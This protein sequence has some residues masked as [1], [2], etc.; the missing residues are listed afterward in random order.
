MK[1]SDIKE[2]TRSQL[3]IW[4]LAGLVVTGLVAAGT[5]YADAQIALALERAFARLDLVTG[6]PNAARV[7]LSVIAGAMVSLLVFTFTM[8]MVVIQLASSQ[9]SP[10]LMRS[11]LRDRPTKISL[12]LFICTFAYALI[13]LRSVIDQPK[14]TVV[15]ELSIGVTY[16]LVLACLFAFIM[17]VDHVAH[18]MR[19]GTVIER[20]IEETLSVINRTKRSVGTPTSHPAPEQLGGG[21]DIRCPT[22][23]S[24]SHLDEKRLLALASKHDATIQILHRVGDHV[25][26]GCP[27]VRIYDA[28]VDDSDIL[29]LISLARTRTMQQDVAFGF[30]QILDIANRALS[31]GINDSTT[32]VQCIDG[33]H[34]LLRRLLDEPDLPAAVAGEQ[35]RGLLLV[36][37]TTWRDYVTLASTEVRI[38]GAGSPQVARRLEAMLRDLYSAAPLDRRAPIEQELRLL[39]ASV[40]EVVALAAD[41]TLFEQPDE[42]GLGGAPYQH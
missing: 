24:V 7:I 19:V 11:V 14:L 32:A 6:D 13:V 42:Q 31:P 4:P 18:T 29:E 35:D 30:R 25:P 38:Y 23:G 2:Y 22:S 12:T 33:L 40:E 17:Y 36:P 20:V 8:T 1:T 5:I 28:D 21:H 39:G 9:Y 10:R 3:W 27:L 37:R 34:D 15:P 41:R 26:P 16:L